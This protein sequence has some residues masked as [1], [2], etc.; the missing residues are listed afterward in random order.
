MNKKGFRNKLA[1]IYANTHLRYAREVESINFSEEMNAASG[2]L[3]V[4]P[5]DAKTVEAARHVLPFLLHFLG[6]DE[7]TSRITTCLHETYKNWI[8]QRM[9]PYAITWNDKDLNMLKLPG[10]KL[11]NKIADM[12]C[13]VAIDL[14][15]D[16]DLA[17]SYLCG[18]TGSR[19]R[20]GIGTKEESDYYNLIFDIPVSDDELKLTYHTL[21]RQLH[22]TFF[23][24]IGDFPESISEYEY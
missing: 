20:I 5:R 18:L 23:R 21:S 3:V 22:R 8:D 1:N 6:G 16:E 24:G 11:L 15:I 17:S 4:M 10:N 14:N 19:V 2:I 9:I 13:S 7:N 12:N